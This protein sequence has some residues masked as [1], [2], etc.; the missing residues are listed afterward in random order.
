L[1]LRMDL[2]TFRDGFSAL[3]L[4]HGVLLVK[5]GRARTAVL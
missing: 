3:V 4:R 1:W 2:G 5:I